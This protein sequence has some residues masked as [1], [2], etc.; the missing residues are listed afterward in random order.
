MS[1]ENKALFR[2][3]FE[4]VWNRGRSEAIEEMFAEDGVAHGLAGESG[5][6]LRGP[7]HF[8]EFHRSF[9]DAFPDIEVVVEDVI[10]EG[11][12]VAGRC[13]ARATHRSASLGFAA[14]HQPVDFD[15]MCIVRICDGKIAEAWNTFDF[16][17]MYRQLGVLDFKTAGGG[18]LP[19]QD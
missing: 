19:S 3:W 14:T 13:S 7:A 2:R 10:A 16:L 15:G 8:R 18:A 9:R 6:E 1:E 11:D 5:A 12:R 17:K 4:E